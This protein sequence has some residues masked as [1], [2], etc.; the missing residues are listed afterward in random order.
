MTICIYPLLNEPAVK[1]P[2]PDL[3]LGTMLGVTA[4][5]VP[6]VIVRDD[7]GVV[8]GVANDD[9]VTGVKLSVVSALQTE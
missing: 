7:L 3:A 1:T 5:V 9:V 4:L 8:V 6:G 2:A